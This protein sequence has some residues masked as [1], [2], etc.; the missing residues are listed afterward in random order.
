MGLRRLDLDFFDDLQL[1]RLLQTL[2]F[3]L[4]QLVPLKCHPQHGLA[5][6][7]FIPEG[8]ALLLESYPIL[9]QLL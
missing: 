1:F 3:P 4:E 2:I 6:R 8:R 9:L 7:N 5:H